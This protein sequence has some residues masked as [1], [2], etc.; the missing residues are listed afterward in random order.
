MWTGR[1][2][3][4][5]FQQYT[6]LSDDKV[7]HLPLSISFKDEFVLSIALKTAVCALHSDKRNPLP[8]F[9]P[10]VYVLALALPHPSLNDTEQYSAG[11][12]II[13][14]VGSSSVGSITTQLTAVAGLHAIAIMGHTILICRSAAGRLSDSI[15]KTHPW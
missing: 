4:G 13:V 7:A 9:L 10:D 3:D 5:A 1:L 6:V 11:K 15:T 12:A 14:Y 2:R 8:D